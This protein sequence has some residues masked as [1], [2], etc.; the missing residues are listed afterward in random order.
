MHNLSIVTKRIVTA[1]FSA[2]Q[3]GLY[4][5]TFERDEIEN[6]A[7]VLNNV[8]QDY[9]NNDYTKAQAMA[10]MHNV[11]LKNK[12]YGAYDSE[13]RQFLDAVLREIYNA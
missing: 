7:N 10:G 5:A 9:V 4:T 12:N 13:P 11:M 3:W 6:I 8:L 1:N 2:D